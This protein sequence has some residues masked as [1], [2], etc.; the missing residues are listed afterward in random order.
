MPKAKLKLIHVPMKILSYLLFILLLATAGC[1]SVKTS[2]KSDTTVS[3]VTS[4]HADSSVNRTSVSDTYGDTLRESNF[5]PAQLLTDTPRVATKDTLPYTITSQSNGIAF[6]ETFTPAYYKG[7][8]IGDQASITAIAKPVTTTNTSE[9]QHSTVSTTATRDS[10]SHV[11]T[12]AKKTIGWSLPSWVWWIA[13][14]ALVGAL[15]YFLKPF[16]KFI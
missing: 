8:F 5:L 13:G 14:I 9:V 2:V 4:I 7:H 12:S 1:G 16:L 10:T 6:K 15:I 3:A 11:Q